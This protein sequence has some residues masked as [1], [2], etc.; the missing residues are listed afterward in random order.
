M[1]EID[2]AY[3]KIRA[4]EQSSYFNLTANDQSELGLALKDALFPGGV[5][6][7]DTPNP[8]ITLEIDG[9]RFRFRMNSDSELRMDSSVMHF[10]LLFQGGIPDG[11][12]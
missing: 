10:S 1:S 7:P 6:N 11:A 8:E 12:H 4:S 2:D 9:K 3:A 5:R